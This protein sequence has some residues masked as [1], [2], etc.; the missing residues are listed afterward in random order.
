MVWGYDRKAI[1]WLRHALVGLRVSVR[2][3]QRLALVDSLH[4]G[5]FNET[6]REA[7]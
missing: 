6:Q 2:P 1:D 3:G 5:I 7:A 4:A